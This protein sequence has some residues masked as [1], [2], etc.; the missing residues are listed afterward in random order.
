MDLGVAG[1]II[2]DLDSGRANALKVQLL[3]RYGPSRCRT[4]SN[5][6]HDIAAADGIVNATQMGMRGFPGCPVPISAIKA[7]HWAADVI[8]TPM[9][10]TFLSAAAATGAR[11]LNGGGMC[12][13]QAV[14]AFQCLTG[15][16]PDVARLHRAFA[17][18]VAARDAALA[19]T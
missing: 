4:T 3:S 15:I 19:V 10:T 6:E 9:Q 17:A 14:A 8:Y 13:H 11:V 5:L 18:A 16:A 2:H 1:L 12:V 7:T